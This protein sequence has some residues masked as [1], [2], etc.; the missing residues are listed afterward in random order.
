MDKENLVQEKYLD[1]AAELFMTHYAAI[2]EETVGEDTDMGNVEFP[3]ELD[4]RCRK[5]IQAHIKQ[6][7]KKVRNKRVLAVLR[8]VAVVAL[9][10]VSTFTIIFYNV[11]AIR[12]PM[13]NFFIEK[14]DTHWEIT[15]TP[16]ESMYDEFNPDDPLRLILPEDFTL[17]SVENSWNLG[18]V[19]ADYANKESQAVHFFTMPISG[20]LVVDT[21]DA[22][23]TTFSL[24]GH[25][26][27]MTE[28]NHIVQVHWNDREAGLCFS[29]ITENIDSETAISYADSVTLFFFP[30]EA[31]SLPAPSAE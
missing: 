13:M 27:I 26:A 31:Y 9:V 30:I 21:E 14:F 10:L 19:I 28:K 4:Q 8:N 11:E 7:R 22:N 24:N 15:Y 29:L 1:A 5:L 25:E 2:L 17:L 3:P 20:T 6:Q 16:P 12:V 18:S 23:V